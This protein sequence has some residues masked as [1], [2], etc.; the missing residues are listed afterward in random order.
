M[1]SFRFGT[2][3]R[4]AGGRTEINAILPTTGGAAFLGAKEVE[5]LGVVERLVNKSGGINGRPIKFVIQ[6]DGGLPQNAV[7]IATGLA[8]KNVNVILRAS[9]AA[10]CGE[11]EPL[12]AKGPVVY[13]LS[14][15]ISPPSGSYMF[16]A[17]VG[18]R[19]FVATSIRYFKAHGWSRIALLTSIDATGRDTDQAF[20]AQVA[21]PESAGVQIVA[22]EHFALQDISVAAQLARIKAAAPQVL[23]AWTTGTAFGNVLRNISDAGITVP[24]FTPSANS[25]MRSSGSTGRSRRSSISPLVPVRPCSQ[26]AASNAMRSSPS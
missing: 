16:S 8:S 14:P 19:D 1:H 7:Q 25:R 11:M 5:T 26:C 22:R 17:N 4:G 21:T 18:S 23:V 6:D 10:L 9:V 20:D 2:A 15:A 12:V 13:C 24:I 3:A